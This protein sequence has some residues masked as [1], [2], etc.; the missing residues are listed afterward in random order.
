MGIES[1][2][3]KDFDKL[4]E[5][6]PAITRE[7]IIETL[8]YLG[9]QCVTRIRDRSAEASWYDQT[10]N[11][12]SSIGY[13]IIDNG[14]TIVDFGFSPSFGKPDRKEKV[15]FTTKDGKEVSFTASKPGG[16]QEGAQKGKV[17]AQSLVSLYS[18]GLTLLI[19]AGMSYAELVEAMKGKDVLASTEIWAKREAPRLMERAKEKIERRIQKYQKQMGL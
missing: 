4:I 1:R 16:G 8:A 7:V 13:L 19:V 6:I 18:R 9:E 17:Y 3:A 2:F 15:E 14:M 11:L 10:G 12:R 5:A